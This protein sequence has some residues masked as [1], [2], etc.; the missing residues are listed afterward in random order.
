MGFFREQSPKRPNKGVSLFWMHHK[1]CVSMLDSPRSIGMRLCVSILLFSVKKMGFI[2]GFFREQRPKRSNKGVFLFWM[3][4]K[5]CASM[6]DSPRS[7]GMRLC[8]SILLF[9]VKSVGFLWF[10]FHTVAKTH[11]RALDFLLRRRNFFS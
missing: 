7:M 3:I 6:L 2:L 1:I 9:S 11:R 10:F 8:V 5:I 4:H